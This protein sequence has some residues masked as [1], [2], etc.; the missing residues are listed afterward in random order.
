MA[1]PP[2]RDFYYPLNVFMHVLTLAEGD[3]SYLHYGFFE[4]DGETIAAAQER[5]TAMLLARLPPPPARLLDV[6]AGLGTTL[7][8][9]TALGYE[10]LGITPDE[11]QIAMIRARHGDAVQTR[12]VRFEDLADRAGFDCLVFQ[13]SSQYIDAEALFAKAAT[14]TSHVL[15]IDEFA[16]ETIAASGSLHP[17]PEFL[18]AAA[19]HGFTKSEDIDVSEKA[20][21]TIDYFIDRLP[22]Y[23]DRLVADLGL[24]GTQIEE[25]I[26]SG[27]NYR[28]LYRRGVYT[29]RL[30]QFR[31]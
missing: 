16:T 22:I 20:P 10:V 13:E 9:L 14:L 23:R 7:R 1:E 27:R 11:K 8:R 26:S 12:C 24:T 18:Q 2:Y 3:V 5:S 17:L 19:R 15:V 21:P 25:L 30:L 28:D 4:A 6:G 31:K 29:Y